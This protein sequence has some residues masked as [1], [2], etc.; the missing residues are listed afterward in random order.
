MGIKKDFFG[1]TENGQNVDTYTLTNKNGMKVIFLNY[2]GIITQLWAPDRNGNLQD[3]VLGYDSM[4]GILRDTACYFGTLVGRYT[5]RIA[6][7]EFSLDGK[8]Y[9]LARNRDGNHLHGGEKG[10]DRVIF[11]VKPVKKG[12]AAALKLT[13]LSKDGEEGYPGNL[14]V[15][16]YYALTD[17]NEFSIEYEATTDKRTI[18]NLTNHMYFNLT[19]DCEKDILQHELM[20][21]ADRY[22]PTDS[23]LIPTG[24]LLPVKGTPL[25]F[26]GIISIGARINDNHPQLKFARGYDLNY[27]LNKKGAEIELAAKVYEP[28]SG[29]TMEILTTEPGVQFYCGNSLDGTMIGKGGKAMKSRSGL[30]LETQHYPDSPNKPNFPSTTLDPGKK[31]HSKTIYKFSSE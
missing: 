17:T 10:F 16:V 28:V 2:G 21:N 26:T 13:Y 18:V 31:Y 19:G 15:T 14:N 1:K 11:D 20:I 6:R 23:G 3:V 12:T 7:G 8:I 24:E 27:V 4:E 9:K 30:C 22:T 25:D 5:N 29:R